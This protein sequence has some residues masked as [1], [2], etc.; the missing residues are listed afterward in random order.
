MSR[1][2]WLG[3]PVLGDQLVLPALLELLPPL[4]SSLP[5]VLDPKPATD[6]SRL[7]A[8]AGA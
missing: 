3:L 6:N 7:P 5:P 1:Q 2:F 4:P 8:D